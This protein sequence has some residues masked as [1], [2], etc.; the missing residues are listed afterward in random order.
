MENI[1]DIPPATVQTESAVGPETPKEVSK[2][3]PKG[4][5]ITI[6]V[7][8]FLVVLC[9]VGY[10]LIT[11]KKPSIPIASP[12]APSPSMGEDFTQQKIWEKTGN[13]SMW[14]VTD[15]SPDNKTAL[16]MYEDKGNPTTYAVD[17]ETGKSI[18]TVDL[19]WGKYSPDGSKIIFGSWLTNAN[20]TNPQKLPALISSPVWSPDGNRL[21]YGDMDAQD[22][23][24]SYLNVYDLQTNK[25]EKIVPALIHQIQWSADGKH[26]LYS[27]G[28]EVQAGLYLLDLTD[29]TTKKILDGPYSFLWNTD[30]T[31]IFYSN[32]EGIFVCD[33]Q[34]E[35]C[36]KIVN[37]DIYYFQLFDSGKL[38][39]TTMSEQDNAKD[40]LWEYDINSKNIRQIGPKE[41]ILANS[42]WFLPGDRAL[43]N[44]TKDIYI[45]A[46]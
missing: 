46:W 21:T 16:L 37:G 20:G 6:V 8:L 38:F 23:N 9:A 40:I 10:L 29:K 31:Q 39:Y 41:G 2:K 42:I 5:L 27:V 4:T 35:N 14:S 12:A 15:I 34:G 26:I 3:P 19:G 32:N 45:I 22:I 25:A 44:G 11:E 17:L 13:S 28:M 43:V 18:F 1:T 24:N 33:N 7:L 30:G 36:Q